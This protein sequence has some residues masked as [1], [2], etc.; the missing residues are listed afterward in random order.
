MIATTRL[1]GC[2]LLVLVP[3]VL[4]VGSSPQG[5]AAEIT[6]CRPPPVAPPYFRA[7]DQALRA[8]RD[9]WGEALLRAREGPTYAR[10]KRYLKPL[11]LARASNEQPLTESGV[12]YVA[13]TNSGSEGATSVALHVADGSEIMSDRVTGAKLTIGV[14]RDGRE[15]FGSCLSRLALPRLGMGYLPILETRYV[16]SVGVRYRQQSFAARMAQFGFAS[17]VR[18]EADAVRARRDAVLR[19]SASEQGPGP[20]LVQRIAQGTSAFVHL[21]RLHTTAHDRLA[22]IEA[23]T[24][25]TVRDA[26]VREWQRRLSEGAAISVP[27]RAV[28]DAARAL[29]L[30]NLGLTWRYSV[31][32]AY[33]QF[34]YP[35]AIDVAEV[36]STYGFFEVGRSILT[37]ALTHTPTRYP[38]WMIG[39]KL[40]GSALYFALSG[41]REYALE[42][43]PT[44]RRYVAR[45]ERQLRASP[46]GLLDRE[47]Y[48]SDVADRVYGLH[49]Q[50]VVLQGLRLIARVWRVDVRLASRCGRLA[51]TLES[52]LRLAVAKSKHR[53]RDGSLFV[54]VRLLDDIPPYDRV[55][56]SRYGS[57]WNLVAPYAL[58]SGLIAPK[59]REARGLLRYLLLHGS[60][61]LGVVRAGAYSLYGK[62]PRYPQSGLNPVY[63][64][65][66]ARFLADNDEPDQ[67]VLSLY[68]QLAAAMTPGTF[69]AGEAVS[70]AP[71][72]GTAYRSTYLPPNGA[73]NASFL[74][75][76]RLMLVHETRGRGG[77]PTGLE[78]AFATPRAWLA[79]GKT[80]DV[81]DV[82]TSF[83]R[84]AFSI[85]SERRTVRVRLNL[86]E[87]ALRPTVRL[88]LR[89]PGERRIAH[90]TLDGR[91][92]RPERA[93]ETLDLTGVTGE[94]EIVATKARGRATRSAPREA[95]IAPR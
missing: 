34:S 75:T 87:H 1:R 9:V 5:A 66:V 73:S 43:T 49:A 57:Y 31:G 24:Y 79:P 22:R 10:V 54:D 61:M 74:E 13:F 55:T 78:L 45:L 39:Q 58:S 92:F 86:P 56:A 64:L 81:R 4:A 63:G 50:A 71:L 77:A 85:A 90:L 88:R 33:E 53:L 48:S 14:G 20:A 72:A 12:H 46:Y 27:E 84:L 30:Q 41:D 29:L 76:L 82:P 93:G 2:S 23:E 19:F 67:L 47:R 6:A 68:G 3:L 70:V 89:L 60:R 18:I 94:H 16:D 15:T 17:L 59:G 80:I 21:L 51:R 25:E 26:L 65:N 38:N 35:E 40:V 95:A 91:P 28:T 52:G 42:A 36:M 69:V 32:N 8:R 62:A 7:V 83:G 44:L 11:L 37:K